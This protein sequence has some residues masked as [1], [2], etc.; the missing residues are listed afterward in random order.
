[1]NWYVVLNPYRTGFCYLRKVGIVSWE[2]T[3]TSKNASI[4]AKLSA[5]SELATGVAD[6][7][8]SIGRNSDAV[9][10]GGSRC[11]DADVRI[12]VET[13]VIGIELGRD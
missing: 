6:H 7:L 4:F 9:L 1:M 2:L 13:E 10:V 3:E 8:R 12:M 5:A 11:A